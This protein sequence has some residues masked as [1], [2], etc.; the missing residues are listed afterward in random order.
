MTPKSRLI[1]A[2]KNESVDRPPAWMMR[3]AGRY[4]PEYRAIK[5]KHSTKEMM[6]TP[7]LAKEITLQPVHLVGTEA[8]ILYSDILMIPDAMGMGLG[9]E[10]GEGPVFDFAVNSREKLR[11]LNTQNLN[12]RLEYVFEAIRLCVQELPPD[13]PL[14]GF[15]GS[16][17]TVACYMIAGGSSKKA[18]NE[19]KALAWKDPE[20]FHD[21]LEVIT[22]ATLAYLSEQFKAGVVAIQLFD[23]WAGL[24]SRED[25]VRFSKPYSQKIFSDLKSQNLPTIHYANNANHLL[26][27]LATMDSNAISVDWRTDLKTAGERTDNRFAIQGN[28]DPD[29]LLTTPQIIAEK[30][31]EMFA[32][33]GNVCKGY[34]VNL[35]HG[36]TPQTP[37]EN[38]K[39]FFDV[40]KGFSPTAP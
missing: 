28:L 21:I 1:S 34:I 3:Q 18:F 22:K 36:V 24:L 38:V 12:S 15:A 35:G 33:R 20:L 5:E 2:L 17:F 8:A 39:M 29:V 7:N 10:T 27:E 6:Q 26:E 13:Y 19:V 23:T 14:L 9:F 30:I 37:V 16:P 32:A 25:Y 11:Q 40:I 31:R 4:L